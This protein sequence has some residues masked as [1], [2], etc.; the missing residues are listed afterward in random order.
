MKVDGEELLLNKFVR[1]MLTAVITCAVSNL[2]A[3]KTD[4]EEKKKI[5]EEWQEVNIR[6]TKD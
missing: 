3:E 6:I 4:P 1:E 2:Q 5:G